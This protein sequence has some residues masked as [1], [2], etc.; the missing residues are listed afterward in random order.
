[1]ND[2]IIGGDWNASLK[3]R[4]GYSGSSGSATAAA[5]ARLG[6]WARETGLVYADPG[7][8][9]WGAGIRQAV[10]D[11]LA[12]G[13]RRFL[14]KDANS[15][16]QPAVFESEDPRH[17]HRGVRAALVD[18]RIG[19]MQELESPRRPVCIRVDGLKLA[20]KTRRQGKN[21]RSVWQQQ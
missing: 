3:D 17:D 13:V 16:D 15:V 20:S 8:F 12:G 1:M 4:I 19:P 18:D 21:I 14:I 9:T 6:S 7:S 11:A 2:V 10:L 5:D